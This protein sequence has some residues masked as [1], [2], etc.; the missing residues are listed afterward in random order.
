MTT[1][2]LEFKSVSVVIDGTDIIKGASFTIAPG[3]FIGLLGPNGAGKSTL[4][5]SAVGLMAANGQR[6]VN[7]AAIETVAPLERA[8]ILSYLPQARPIFW[9]LPVRNIVALG[10]F[11]YGAA[12]I[13]DHPAVDNAMRET[14]IARLANRPASELSGGEL[15]R[16]HLARALAAQAPLVLADEPIAALDPAHQFSTLTLLRRKADEGCAVI[17]ALHDLSLAARYCTRLIIMNDGVI[18]AD[19]PPSILDEESAAKIF[20]IQLRQVD[21]GTGFSLSPLAGE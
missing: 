6:L 5:R 14:G 18:A 9:S 3:E 12:D 11:A 7:G 1:S 8:K 16:V 10:R 17:A 19:G 13:L 21:S 20:Q 2:L 15:A 4:L